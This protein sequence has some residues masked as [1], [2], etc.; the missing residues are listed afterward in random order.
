MLEHPWDKSTTGR[1]TILQ[2]GGKGHAP[3][4]LLANLRRR[5]SCLIRLTIHPYARTPTAYDPCWSSP[6]LLQETYVLI[7]HTYA[8][9]PTVHDPSWSSTYL[10]KGTYVWVPG[11]SIAGISLPDLRHDCIRQTHTGKQHRMIQH[12]RAFSVSRHCYPH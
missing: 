5:P 3:L 10:L 1:G 4:L 2:G 9:E 12:G 11:H 6:R 7:V 8:R